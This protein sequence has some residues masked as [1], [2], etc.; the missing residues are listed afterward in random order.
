MTPAQRAAFFTL[1][2]GLPRQGPGTRRDLDWACR[3]AGVTPDARI[4][5]AG[6]G[7][8]ADI[9]GLLAHAPRGHVLAVDTHAPFVDEVATR[10]SGDA[11]VQT[12]AGDMVD[13][14]GPFDFVWCAGALYFLGVANGLRIMAEK[15]DTDGAIAF[16]HLV[17]TVAAPDPAVRRV[18]DAEPDV[19]GHMAL[20]ALIENT[21]FKLHGQ[22]VMPNASWDA[23]YEPMRTRIAKLRPDADE[24]LSAVLNEAEAEIAL[25]DSFPRHFSY[26]TSV[27]TPT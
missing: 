15:L 23:Y 24:H 18:F 8:G 13:A 3:I 16:S 11:R 6:C 21:G 19:M 1:H 7:P 10:F 2:E 26:V 27:V 22:R 12:V 14:R 17:Y 25:R 20:Q 5:D 9:E 4:L